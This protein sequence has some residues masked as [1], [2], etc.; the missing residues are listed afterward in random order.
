M[1]L[2]DRLSAPGH[3]P[4]NPLA[5][6]GAHRSAPAE[7]PARGDNAPGAVPF[8]AQEFA[9]NPTRATSV[10]GAGAA[11]EAASTGRAAPARGDAPA[12]SPASGTHPASI[13]DDDLDVLIEH[14]RA[15]LDSRILSTAVLA[16]LL[17]FLVDPRDLLVLICFMFAGYVLCDRF[18][19]VRR[20]ASLG[21]SVWLA[22]LLVGNALLLAAGP[23]RISVDYFFTFC[24]FFLAVAV[25]GMFFTGRSLYYYGCDQGR[26]EADRA[27]A[28]H[29]VDRLVE[30]PDD[31]GN[32]DGDYLEVEGALNRVR[33]RER[34]SSQA[35]RDESRR[36]D[37]LVTYLA[38]DLKT[39]LAS[40]VGYLSLLEE[41][42]DLPAEQRARFTGIALEK[43]H[44]LDALIEE[45][46]D[47]TRFD[48]HDMVLTRGYVNLDLML[49]QV[50]EEFYPTLSAQGKQAHIDVPVGLTVLV[51]GDKMARVFN[52]VMKNAI[53]YSYENST[54]NVTGELLDAAAAKN[55]GLPALTAGEGE[56]AASGEAVR[57]RF[58]NQGDPIPAPKLKLIFEKFYRLDAARAT[59]RGGAGLGLAIAKEIVCAHGGLIS[60]E[61]T[62]EHTAFEIVLPAR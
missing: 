55:L 22:A 39:P 8:G 54:I 9:E 19:W 18:V 56:V 4:V 27:I 48:F 28:R 25:C 30:N 31:W 15:I 57:I 47:I 10:P 12:V 32:L 37:D 43:A 41:A 52:N 24:G 50:A 38:H 62:P 7:N 44:R 34:A 6:S 20:A 2:T 60:C 13:R 1:K 3:A 33:E 46:F 59:N 53:A 42:P 5:T 49:A 23:M 29:V 26:A 11:P 14:A 45:F 36:K 35:V 61:S 58:E 17:L 51:D 40:V 21:G 16:L